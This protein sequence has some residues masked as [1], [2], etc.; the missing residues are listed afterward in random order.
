MTPRMP[1]SGQRM[2]EVY[3]VST[4]EHVASLWLPGPE[5]ALQS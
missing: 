1:V 4:G 5:G 2:S 3:A